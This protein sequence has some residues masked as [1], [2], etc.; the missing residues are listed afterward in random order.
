MANTVEIKVAVS[1]QAQA[2]AD[3]QSVAA[4][5]RDVH[6][7]TMRALAAARGHDGL[8]ALS[9]RYRDAGQAAAGAGASFGKLTV[10]GAVGR[11]VSEGA[12]SLQSFA[13]SA[14]DAADATLKAS[15]KSGI[16]AAEYQRLAYAARLSGA[17]MGSVEV[18]MKT[19]QVAIA[20]GDKDLAKLGLDLGSLAASSP[21]QQF[22]QV[23]AAVAAI[24]DPARRTAA[25]VAAFGRSG[26]ELLPMLSG[27]REMRDEAD[28]LGLVLDEK[29][30]AA[31]ERFN[32]TLEKLKA[33]AQSKIVVAV[34]YVESF[35]RPGGEAG[36]APGLSA[37]SS[38]GL[39]TAGGAV[40]GGAVGFLA[41]GPAGAARGASRGAVAGGALAAG[42][43]ASGSEDQARA[44][45]NEVVETG[46]MAVLGGSA[47]VVLS[48]GNPA[49]FPAGAK[50]GAAAYSAGRM[51]ID[52]AARRLVRPDARTAYDV[53]DDYIA[54]A[55]QAE[56]ERAKARAASAVTVTPMLDEDAAR[57]AESLAAVRKALREAVR[58]AR[59]AEAAG[60]EAGVALWRALTGLAEVRDL[61]ADEVDAILR[62]AVTT[63][64]SIN[65]AGQPD[66]EFGYRLVLA[67]AKARAEAER[68]G[69]RLAKEA[70]VER[71][72]IEKDIASAQERLDAETA[73]RE[74]AAALARIA[75]SR[76]TTAA[77]IAAAREDAA[78]F[79]AAGEEL[80]GKAAAMRDRLL[81]P[82]ADRRAADDAERDRERDG[83]RLERGIGKARA[84]AQELLDRGLD[85]DEV[86][87]R[88]SR[89]SRELLEYDQTRRAQSRQEQAATAAEAEAVAAQKHLA[90]LEVEANKL[91]SVQVDVTRE[92]VAE[93]A[94]LRQKLAE[95]LGPGVEPAE[96]RAPAF[97]PPSPSATQPEQAPPSA[98]PQTPAPVVAEVAPAVVQGT[99]TPQAPAPVVAEVA[100]AVVQST[101][102]PQAPAPAVA[103]VAPAV[104]QSTRTPQAPAP[105]VAEVA[106]AVVQG[107]RTPQAPAP[108]VAEVA[109]AVVQGTRTPQAPAPVV[110]EVAPAV[111]Q[112]TR[113]PQALLSAPSGSPDQSNDPNSPAFDVDAALRRHFARLRD[114]EVPPAPVSV[115]DVYRGDAGAP[116]WV[117]DPRQTAPASRNE[118]S[119]SANTDLLRR[120]VHNTERLIS[121][122]HQFSVFS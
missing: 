25:A 82:D 57:Y 34:E 30:L 122:M 15:V 16:S 91:R 93:L 26:T 119:S 58:E 88:L 12:L 49:A 83:E 95:L 53:S 99:R 7:S 32:D 8:D 40:V 17:S 18:A 46:G 65:P 98:T 27:L 14:L 108:V 29:A 70:A 77:T 66:V 116:N 92:L 9:A 84:K 31:A 68:E 76:R 114:R 96:P 33:V 105:A 87:R 55:R 112:G 6:D 2:A 42:T 59:A 85:E 19:L 54:A 103:E 81:M 56:E 89:R 73:A 51:G 45:K 118:A 52:L 121:E 72:A 36:G 37:T 47:A 48:G 113:T 63:D 74:K 104:V 80:A 97:S 110:A 64:A 90:E 20:S 75:E 62:S 79:K 111:V 28:R 67:K 41:G 60:D 3:L 23:A 24:E 21:D 39:L 5:L 115:P 13:R 61:R 102:T 71:Q 50:L 117:L 1:G 10:A 35:V 38:A 4:R 43:M 100:P 44:L 94:R 106:P 101:R 22:L 107:T 86:K 69:A 120:I 78:K 109:P 11:M